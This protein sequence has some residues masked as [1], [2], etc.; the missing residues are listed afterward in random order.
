M[1][2]DSPSSARPGRAGPRIRLGGFVIHGDATGTLPACLDG[3]L[4]ACDEVVCV[5][6]GTSQAGAALASSRGI[7]RVA[8]RWEGFGAARA[9]AVEQLHGNDY[10]LF[11]DS[12]ERLTPEAI[13]ALDRWRSS[14]PEAPYYSIPVRDWAELGG[15]RFLYRVEHHVRIVRSDRAAWTAD[16][17]VH[18]ALPAAHPVR[19]DEVVVEHQFATST[20]ELAAKVERYAL[21]WALR[22]ARTARRPKPGWAQ[23]PWHV[24]R[25]CLL[26]GAL[27][28]GGLDAAR[29]A[30]LVSA[31][32]A[33][34]YAHLAALRRGASRP[35]QEAF[36]AG[37][38]Q[39][40]F[41]ELR[42]ALPLRHSADGAR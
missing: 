30:W 12:D 31:Y 19:L 28:R 26:K 24:L 42:A 38:Y 23:R 20:T 15:R 10:L 11:L 3:L 34:K 2:S 21:L 7:R 37:R 41:E 25:D 36:L 22:Y 32:H 18:E 5:D 35:L 33:R 1:I 6:S 16:M 27:F 39:E 4:G 14:R 9:T 40:L 8:R 13:E 29:L 17:I